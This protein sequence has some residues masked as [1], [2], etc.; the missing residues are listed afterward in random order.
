MKF[1]ARAAVLLKKV[2]PV[3][4]GL[5]V[6]V[7]VIG[8]LA[9]IFVKKI[10]PGR[11][12]E[13][14]A[15]ESVPAGDTYVVREIVKTYV[16]ESVGTLKAS[17]R[18]E[19]SSRVQAVIT[20]MAV[21]A[22]DAV[23]AGD[24]LVELDRAAFERQLSQLKESLAAAEAAL[25]QAADAHAR[26]AKLHKSKVIADAEFE[27][28]V[29]AFDQ[30]QAK[31]NQAEEAVAE[32]EIL[33]SYAI[34]K[35]PKPGLIVDRLAEEG[36]LA[37]PGYPLLALYDPTSLR[38]EV[39]VSER[40]A[41]RLKVGDKLEVYIDSIDRVFPAAV[42]EKVPQ[43][44]AASRSFLVKVKLPPSDDI[45]EGM[46]G[47]LR[48]PAGNRPHLCLHSAA[49][50]RIG[51]LEFVDVVDPVDSSLKRRLIKTGRPGDADHVEVL[52]GL[53]VGEKVVLHTSAPR[54]D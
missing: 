27:Q 48:I 4:V 37:R 23:E 20:R 29:S 47:R 18:T 21:R 13:S 8:V 40:L 1:K 36:D 25:T 15:G 35:A 12:S 46:F 43:A 3:V 42:D 53:D 14:A 32:S 7:G 49:I 33:L 30:A 45:F 38:L 31:R 26:Y 17:S 22:G 9:G 24:V 5:V 50:Q 16:E 6:L 41:A 34:I 2:V 54:V 11:T 51:Q 19:I 10:Q 28:A 52:S 39:P 44:L